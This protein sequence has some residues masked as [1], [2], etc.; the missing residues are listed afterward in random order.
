MTALLTLAREG[1]A[2]QHRMPLI[3]SGSSAGA[4]LA[5][6]LARGPTD[7]ALRAQVT[8]IVTGADLSTL[9]NKIVLAKLSEHFKVDLESRKAAIKVMIQEALAS[10]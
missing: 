10:V 9:T 5:A 1:G 8:A 3:L 7:D 2:G 6:S 4:G